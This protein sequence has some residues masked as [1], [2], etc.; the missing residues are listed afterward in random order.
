MCSCHSILECCVT[1][2]GVRLSIRSFV[3]LLLEILHVYRILQLNSTCVKN[4]LLW[5]LK[6]EKWPFVEKTKAN[7]VFHC[8][9]WSLLSFLENLVINC[10]HWYVILV[11]F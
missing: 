5:Q 6:R 1:F 10:L 2:S 3:L 4:A 11:G 7:L 8:R 9:T